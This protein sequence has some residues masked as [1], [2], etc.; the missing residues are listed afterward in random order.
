MQTRFDMNELFL[1]SRSTISMVIDLFGLDMIKS[2]LMESFFS[3]FWT[4]FLQ[5]IR[6]LTEGQGYADDY[7]GYA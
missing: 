7:D 1:N 6:A 3:P 5:E 4:I 2:F